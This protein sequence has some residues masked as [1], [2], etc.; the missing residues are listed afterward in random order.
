[1]IR[2][3]GG[4]DR[5]ITIQQVT[6]TPNSYGTPVETWSD[7]MTLRARKLDGAVSDV[8]ENGVAVSDTTFVFQTYWQDGITLDNRV[9]YNGVAYLIKKIH[10]IGRREGMELHVERPG[11]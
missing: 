4:M 6:R 5:Q 11:V 1:M 2:R 3:A 8:M 7:L 9:S 10:E